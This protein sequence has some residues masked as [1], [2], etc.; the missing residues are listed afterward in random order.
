[1]D[2][3]FER[4]SSDDVFFQAYLSFNPGYSPNGG[5]IYPDNY[6][7]IYSR[8]QQPD[9]GQHSKSYTVENLASS[10][11]Y[12]SSNAYPNIVPGPHYPVPMSSA[13][14]YLFGGLEPSLMQRTYAIPPGM[15][16]MGNP[17]PYNGSYSSSFDAYPAP[18][19][20]IH[21]PSPNYPG[22]TAPSGTGGTTPPSYHIPSHRPPVDLVYDGV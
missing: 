19:A 7:A 2:D 6:G 5:G 18:P 10:T 3:S 14:G 13:N 4:R 9:N 22:Y 16:P 8:Q 15:H 21:A 17:Y 1:M 12:S 11:N 20:G